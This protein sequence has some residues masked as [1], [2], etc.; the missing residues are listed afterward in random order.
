[1]IPTTCRHHDELGEQTSS[2]LASGDDCYVTIEHDFIIDLP[3]KSGDFPT[4][5]VCLP[6]I[7][8]K[9]LS[10]SIVQNLP[11]NSSVS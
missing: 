1:M 10:Q 5:F 9:D 6:G 2:E 8:G 11:T 4:F 7:Q 3:I